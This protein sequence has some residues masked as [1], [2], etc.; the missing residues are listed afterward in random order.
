MWIS[1]NSMPGTYNRFVDRVLVSVSIEAALSHLPVCW[2]P[3]R[4]CAILIVHRALGHPP[5]EIQLLMS[6]VSKEPSF[7][8]KDMRA[9]QLALQQLARKDRP[10]DRVPL[11]RRPLLDLNR[12]GE[13]KRMVVGGERPVFGHHGSVL[14]P[15]KPVAAALSRIQDENVPPIEAAPVKTVTPR[16]YRMRIGVHWMSYGVGRVRHFA[17]FVLGGL[18]ENDRVE[19][20][21]SVVNGRDVGYM[22]FGK[23]DDLINSL[24]K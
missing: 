11:M 15:A 13:A 1:T 23:R 3:V 5:A 19:V 22:V 17:T 14:E 6:M 2:N 24:I 21:M 4:A 9:V 18:C 16:W 20:C 10:V 8:P 7:R 12:I